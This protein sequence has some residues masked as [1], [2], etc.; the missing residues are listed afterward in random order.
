M[1]G[2]ND[3]RRDA[4]VNAIEQVL[5]CVV[6]IATES[7]VEYHDFYDALLRQFYGAQPRTRVDL[8]SGV[9]IDEEGYVLTNFHV[10]RRATRIQVKLWDGR[11]FEADPIVATDASDVALIKIRIKPGQKFK[12]IRFAADDDLL[13]GETVIALGNPFGLGG[14]VTRGILSSKNRRPSTGNEPLDVQDWLQTDAAINPGNSGGPLVNLRGELI[15]L[16]VAV[17][18]EEQGERGVGVG[19]SIPIKHVSAALSRFFTPEVSSALWLGAQFK[20][21]AGALV[22]SM[23]QPGSPA[24]RAGLKVGHQLLEVD[25]QPVQTLMACN[26]LL[27]KEKDRRRVQLSVSWRRERHVVKVELLGF[28]E[29]MREKL[30]MELGPLDR[31]K[32]RAAVNLGDALVIEDVEEAGPAARARLQKGYLVS[33]IEAQEASNTRAVMG[34]MSSV[35]PGETV[36]VSVIVPRRLGGNYVEFQ[37]ASVDLKAR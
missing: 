37:R 30:G 19:F 4:T 12:A 10:V 33:A 14:S 15:G 11:E 23:V 36:R 25:G 18:R 5:P 28:K 16:N 26:R 13:L 1:P 17:Y 21:G 24:D 34:L 27:T 7:V 35:P 8:G 22:V 29:M 31:Q 3:I 20:A 6:N 32:F 9:I 2:T